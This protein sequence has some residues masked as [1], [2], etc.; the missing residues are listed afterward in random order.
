MV[1]GKIDVNN[2][3]QT[4]ANM[5]QD[6]FSLMAM[7]SYALDRLQ[8]RCVN[9]NGACVGVQTDIHLSSSI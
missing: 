2:T 4:I 7:Q 6:S 3:S 8:Y 5:G 1:V 9:G